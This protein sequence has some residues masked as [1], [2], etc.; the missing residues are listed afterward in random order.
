MNADA[1]SRSPVAESHPLWNPLEVVA[2][3]SISKASSKKGSSY[4]V[5]RKAE[6]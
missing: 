6:V 1:L 4:P 5:R 2:V 3:I